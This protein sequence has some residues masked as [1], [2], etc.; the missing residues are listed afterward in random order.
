MKFDER[1]LELLTPFLEKLARILKEHEID[2]L[3]V[4]FQEGKIRLTRNHPVNGSPS[5]VVMAGSMPSPT[6]TPPSPAPSPA[7]ASET[8]SPM[9]PVH[10]SEEEKPSYHPI[11]S[12]IVGTFYRAPAPGEAPFVE[13]GDEV[14]K[15]QVLCIVEAMKVMNEIESDV[16][17][18]VV[19]ILVKNGEPVEYG[20]VLF[21]IDTSPASS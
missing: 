8:A 12:P 6:P 13:V 2:E 3:E 11:R 19:D 10:T 14:K 15:G 1:H 16:D 4:T 17:G 5:T 18:R 7:P 21:L 9:P 20:Q